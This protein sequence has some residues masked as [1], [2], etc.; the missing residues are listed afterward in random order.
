MFFEK[1]KSYFYFVSYLRFGQVRSRLL[2]LIKRNFLQ[3]N[4]LPLQLTASWLFKDPLPLNRIDVTVKQAPSGSESL[5]LKVDLVGIS[6]IIDV[7]IDWDPK[8]LNFGTRLEKLNLH[9]MEYLKKLAPHLALQIM[10]DWVNSVPPYM[11]QYWKDSW[12]SYALSIRVV[13]WF[14]ILSAVPDL[15]RT[16]KLNSIIRSL[17]SQVRF[18]SRNLEDDI[19]GNHLVKNLKCLARASAFFEGSEVR[20]YFKLVVR[21]LSEQLDDQILSDGMHFELSPSYHLQVMEDL[22]DIR[23]ALSSPACRNLQ[24][25]RSADLIVKL[26]CKLSQMASVLQRMTHPDGYPSLMADGGMHMA[27]SPKVVLESLVHDGILPASELLSSSNDSWLLPEAGYA[28]LSSSKSLF[29]VDC[30]PV[31]APHLPAHGH[32]DALSFEWSVRGERVFVDPGV[33]EYHSGPSRAYSRSTASH[34]TLTLCGL[35]Q[36]EFFSSF[37]VG[38]RANVTISSWEQND[39]GF[40]LVASHDGYSGLSGSPVHR[41]T[42][43]CC[44]EYFEIIDEVLGGCAQEASSSIL[45][46]PNVSVV[47]LSSSAELGTTVEL[48]VCPVNTSSDRF[49]V[50]LSSSAAVRVEDSVFYPDLGVSIPTKRLLFDHGR[51]PCS[52]S[53]VVSVAR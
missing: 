50:Q 27:S 29:I 22:I 15:P 46:G 26:G 41:R 21:L 7:G 13:V 5:P 43:V 24:T 1:F 30:G 45:L 42:V 20:G 52:K 18:L 53:F 4:I 16:N 11:H 23:R 25:N 14:D 39:D 6:W 32:G 17:S 8:E 48:V 35:D 28:G 31:G 2:L 40:R 33:Y 19:G 12:N 34:N 37:R 38:K 51:A 10:H 3:L 47:S 44:H 9:Y 49:S 36:S